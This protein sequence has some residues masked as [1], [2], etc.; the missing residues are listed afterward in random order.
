MNIDELEAEIARLE[1]ELARRRAEYQAAL[2]EITRKRKAATLKS[3][4]A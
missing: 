3:R 1:A 2:D 4:E